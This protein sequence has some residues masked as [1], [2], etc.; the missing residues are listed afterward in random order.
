MAALF[1]E[2]FSTDDVGALALL[3][4]DAWLSMPPAPYEYHGVEAIA[5]FLHASAAGRSG[6]R[7]GLLPTRANGQPAFA[8]YLGQ[9]NDAA[10]HTSGLIVLT[11][12]GNRIATIT[13]FLDPEL[14][15]I[16]GFENTHA[17]AE[18]A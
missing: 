6:R 13:R 16:F 14:P 4:D 15:S 12:P 3:T 1:A 10:A 18:G 11:L 9:P 2:A 17:R 5:G 8:C 7:L